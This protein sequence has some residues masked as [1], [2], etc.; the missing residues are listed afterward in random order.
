M[1][2]EYTMARTKSSQLNRTF[3]GTGDDSSEEQVTVDGEV[4][5][6]LEQVAV[7][8]AEEDGKNR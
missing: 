4:E 7:V 3:V 5:Q 6:D 1:L 2:S 8:P